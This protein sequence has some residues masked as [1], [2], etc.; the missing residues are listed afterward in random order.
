MKDIITI[1][2]LFVGPVAAVLTQ[3]WFERRREVRRQKLW[4][5]TTLMSNRGAVLSLDFVRALNAIEVV[6]YQNSMIRKRFKDL[7]SHLSSNNWKEIPVPPETLEKTRDLIAQLLGEM[8][9]ELNYTYDH[10]EIKDGA[11][12]PQFLAE[13][14]EGFRKLRDELLAVLK[15]NQNI[16]VTLH[17]E[18]AHYP[19]R[20]PIPRAFSG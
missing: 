12:Y 4:V 15:G 8:A 18:Q 19:E 14:D 10:T 17:D 5:F 11:Y 13:Q 6:F 20:I 3:L 2:A 7:L 16:G 1:V 9:S